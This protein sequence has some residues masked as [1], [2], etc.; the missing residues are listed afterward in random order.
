MKNIILVIVLFSIFSC[1]KE[2]VE[3]IPNIAN[4]LEVYIDLNPEFR[5]V[6]DS[7][8]ACAAG[9]QSNFLVDADRPISIFFYP[10]G[11]AM[12]FEYFETDS[13]NVDP[14]NLA[15]YH[16]VELPDEPILNGY[17]RHFKREAPDQN[18]WS[19]VSFVK[20]GNLHISNPI[21]IKY[22]NT[23]TEYNAD[24]LMIDQGTPL[25]PIFQWEDGVVAEN[26]IYFQIISDRDNNL[27]SG[28]YTFEKHFQFYDL[29]NVVLNVSPTSPTPS[30]Q[31]Q[32]EYSFVM[33]G[34]SIDNWVNLIVEGQFDTL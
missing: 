1:K 32:Q 18:I 13:I 25:S 10:E 23:P 20:D 14:N 11:N 30:L 8:I 29:S 12:E 5:L 27:I 4:N 6:K 15:N 21:R 7:L 2:T 22:N 9:G 24:V 28:T 19:I 31:T 33:M 34:V 17:I 16:R 3:L 26:E